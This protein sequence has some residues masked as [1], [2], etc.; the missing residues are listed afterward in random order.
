MRGL[1]MLGSMSPTDD[2]LVNHRAVDLTSPPV[3]AAQSEVRFDVSS[4]LAARLRNASRQNQL[5][6]SR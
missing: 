2:V 1:A 5:S 6:S 3:Q 4:S